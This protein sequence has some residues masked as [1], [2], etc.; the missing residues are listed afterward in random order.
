MR[1]PSTPVIVSPATS[2]FT[3]ASSV[4]CTVASKRALM[5][6][7]D[8]I[9]TCACS[10]CAA[11]AALEAVADHAGTAADV[12]FRNTT[13]R[14]GVERG[15]DVIGLHV[16]PVDVVQHTVPRFRDDGQRPG[17]RRDAVLDG[18]FDRRVADDADA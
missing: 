13:R 4:A 9:V 17:L 6:A 15:E 10:R 7:F 2:A 16:K 1:W 8:T 14:R 12:A 11:A 18:P 3:I 5:R